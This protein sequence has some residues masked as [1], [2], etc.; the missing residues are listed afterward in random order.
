LD[1]NGNPKPDSAK[2]DK[3]SVPLEVT[4]IE[5]YFE[6]EVL[7]H[8]PGAWIDYDKTRI[9]YEINFTKYFYQYKGLRPSAE[10][11]AEIETI[12]IWFNKE[13]RVLLNY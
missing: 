9:G 5:L 13:K 11:K 3:E 10:I 4:D 7:P 12:R 8:V 2:R 1:K 6:T